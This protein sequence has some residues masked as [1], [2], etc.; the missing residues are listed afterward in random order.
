MK[1]KFDIITIGGATEDISVLINNY[2]LIDNHREV[3]VKKLLAIEYGAK[4]IVDKSFVEYGGGAANLAI[5]IKQCGLSVASWLAVGPDRRGQD[6]IDNLKKHKVDTGLC[7]IIN[8]QQSALSVVLIGKD[9]EHTIFAYRG[10][11]DYLSITSS[12]VKQ[13]T[14]DWLYISSLSGK[15]WLKNLTAI[16][17]NHKKIAWNPGQAQLAAGFKKLR[18]FLEKTE[19]LIVNRD[20]ALQLLASRPLDKKQL[21]D[22]DQDIKKL[23]Q[24]LWCYG[25]KIVVITA[26]SQG[27]W[28]YDGQTI[29]HQP[30]LPVKKIIDTT[31]VGDA[32]G[33]T[34][35]ACFIRTNNL[36]KSLR[37]AAKQA[38]AVMSQRGAQSGLLNISQLVR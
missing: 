33:G 11:N 37:L 20:E 28:S 29:I 30:A 16:F 18:P 21:A 24:R 8:R 27:A 7:Q 26:D 25:P 6:I 23:I 3:L 14:S 9:G 36:K 32:F 13:L 4:T 34:L 5:A 19:L 31:G 2:R 22:Y 1:K 17:K 12:A 15:V 38:A 10:A 35:L